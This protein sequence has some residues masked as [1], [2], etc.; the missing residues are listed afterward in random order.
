MSKFKESFTTDDAII[1][2]WMRDMCIKLDND[3]STELYV[4]PKGSRI[5]CYVI[6]NFISKQHIFTICKGVYLYDVQGIC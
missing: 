4:H 6:Q 2:Q 5:L 3:K 1:E